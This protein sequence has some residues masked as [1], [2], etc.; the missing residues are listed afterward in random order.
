MVS[1]A[2]RVKYLVTALHI[3]YLHPSIQSCDLMSF[4]PANLRKGTKVWNSHGRATLLFTIT[5]PSL[6][7]IRSSVCTHHVDCDMGHT[8]LVKD[9]GT[10]MCVVALT[11][12]WPCSPYSCAFFSHSLPVQVL[13]SYQGRMTEQTM[14]FTLPWSQSVGLYGGICRM[15]MQVLTWKGTRRSYL[16]G[17]AFVVSMT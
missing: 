6:P 16:S 7:D 8:V 13:W 14:A 2:W 3:H 15:S 12:H 5:S 17:W 11:A 1:S 4:E 10:A 9:N